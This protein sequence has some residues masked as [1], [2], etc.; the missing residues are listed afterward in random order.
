[1]L[2]LGVIKL[3]RGPGSRDSTADY[4]TVTTSAAHAP[5]EV[6]RAVFSSNVTLEDL[7]S[8]LDDARLRIV[9]GPTEAGVYSLA[10]TSLRPVSVSLSLLREHAAVRFAESTD[11]GLGIGHRLVA[12]CLTFAKA[13]GYAKMM[14]WTNDVL[15]S[16]RNIYEAAGFTLLEESPY[17]SFGQ[18]LVG[19]GWTKEL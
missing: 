17:R 9:A 14:L 1:M 4:R 8:I 7:Q 13:A 12:Q 15:S 6:I 19:Q 3:A 2:L 5:G 10:R 16:A 18:D 11:G